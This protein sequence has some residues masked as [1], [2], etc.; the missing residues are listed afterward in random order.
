MHTL[1]VLR[2]SVGTTWLF[3]V[4]SWGGDSTKKV[5]GLVC[6]LGGG[7]GGG[8]GVPLRDIVQT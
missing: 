1:G 5:G 8:G 2:V 6:Y 7:G 3:L 4:W